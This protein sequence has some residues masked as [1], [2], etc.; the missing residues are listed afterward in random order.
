MEQTVGETNLCDTPQP[1]SSGYN[2]RILIIDDNRSIHDDFRKILCPRSHSSVAMDST[3]QMLFGE[4]EPSL[5]TTSFEVDS[6]YQGQEGLLTVEK[7]LEENRPFAM[8]FVDVRMPPGWDGIETTLKI[9][10]KYPDL[11]VVICTAYSDYS[12]DE[13]IAKIGNSDRLLIL[14]KPFDSVEAL[15]LAHALTEKWRLVQTAKM[16]MTD[17]K[18]I[19]QKRT[20]KLKEINQLLQQE[21]AG[22]IKTEEDL[23]V[24]KKTAEEANLNLI[25]L[26]QKLV[27]AVECSKQMTQVAETANQAKSQFLA[28]MSHEI[29]T[30]MNGVLGMVD[31]LL[32]GKL[33]E[34]QRDFAQTIRTS[35]DALLTIL[36]DILDFSKMEAD[37]LTF[38]ILSFRLDEVVESTLE[39]L[40]QRAQAKGVELINYTERGIPKLVRGGS[41]RLRQV[42]TNLVSNAIKFTPRGEVVVRISKSMENETHVG[43]RFSVKDTGIGISAAEQAKLFQVFSQA[44]AST[45]RK[46]GGTG[47]GLAISKQLINKMGGAIGVE[48]E[49]GK[50]STFWFTVQLEKQ[51]VAEVSSERPHDVDFLKNKRILVV[52]DSTTHCEVLHDQLGDW[53]M[54]IHSVASGADALTELQRAAS[55][56]NPYEVALVDLEMPMM[57]GLSLAWAIKATPSIGATKL[58]LLCPQGYHVDQN[59]LETSAIQ[60]SLA[61]PVRQSQLYGSLLNLL[62]EGE[63]PSTAARPAATIPPPAACDLRILIAEDNLINQR[64]LLNQLK[65]LGCTA[66]IAS[67]GKGVLSAL[68]VAPYDLILMDC[69][70]PEMDGYEAVQIIRHRES[71][72]SG[73][74]TYIVALTASAMDEDRERCF[75]AGMDGYLSKP[76]RPTELASTIETIKS[77]ASGS[78]FTLTLP[79][80][81]A[82]L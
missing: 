36:N 2:R 69:Q 72:K 51:P 55:E 15:Q 78:I 26:N 30:P 58:I 65:K 18:T 44:D 7:S 37:K 61:K 63:A 59:T 10:E 77:L 42:L 16:K 52:D 38:E 11:Q 20:I 3:E 4:S 19:V 32:D 53:E 73:P 22:H 74:K 29:R 64:V 23:L 9:W 21:I 35:A 75:K 76:L 50:G 67:T 57:N 80:A 47:L 62:G 70:M 24:A 27:T 6:A 39:L 5:P 12:W 43:L 81:L 66:D 40:A 41:V 79:L 31:M 28:N 46:Y 1:L 48:S 17:L 71:T 45:T 82:P 8:A 68:E 33:D 34:E 54:A 49:A 25:T 56:Q 14:K 13:M 60:D